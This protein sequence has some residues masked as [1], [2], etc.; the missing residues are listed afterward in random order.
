[1]CISLFTFTF[2]AISR[3]ASLSRPTALQRSFAVLYLYGISWVFLVINTYYMSRRN[4]GAG[5]FTVFFNMLVFLA[6]LVTMCEFFALTRKSD[7]LSKMMGSEAE[8][9]VPRRRESIE[10]D[11]GH[12]NSV[13]LETTGFM[14]HH[15]TS[16]AKNGRGVTVIVDGLRRLPQD[17]FS[18][19]TKPAAGDEI[20][21]RDLPSWTWMLQFIIIGP[22]TVIFICNI[23]LLL[24]SS[25]SQTLTSTTF[26]VLLIGIFSILLMLPITPFA[27][28][29]T[30]PIPLFFLL[31]FLGSF[32]FNLVVFPFNADNRY[33][34][35]FLQTID[36]DT[37][38]SVVKL[39][40]LENYV[41][42]I[43]AALPSATGKQ[44]NCTAS[45]NAVCQY[46]ASAVLPNITLAPTS[47]KGS[48]TSS[49][50]MN[51]WVAYN[52]SRT[53][54]GQNRAVF[55]IDAVNSKACRLE[56]D[57]V[58]IS[59]FSVLGGV[60]LDSRFGNVPPG[61]LDLIQLWRR[62]WDKVWQVTIE[63]QAPPA[64]KGGNGDGGEHTELRRRQVERPRQTSTTPL[65]GRV[66]CA[67]ADA[68]VPGTI[69]A[70]DEIWRHAP[71]WATITRGAEGLVEG[72]KAF[73][74]S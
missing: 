35:M 15:G 68:N 27:H 72:S 18:R 13:A 9:L 8:E 33:K 3:R 46:D 36:L 43:I 63:W 51:N 32:I 62:D 53:S 64:T 40:G 11:A 69:P 37:G 22:A 54:P 2:W 70:V 6:A 52:V 34:P 4:V 24:S 65:R 47:S 59:N 7:V 14:Y 1:M 10:Y 58:P 48:R 21:A 60:G 74:I 26:P 55:I 50:G 31:A 16:S 12:E 56:F 44:V 42:P 73:T 29:L 20:W 49:A 61:G 71:S 41:R 19:W 66:V 30:F 25:M 38:A 67:W 17:E 39:T 28:R 5:Y 45:R 57:N 23:G